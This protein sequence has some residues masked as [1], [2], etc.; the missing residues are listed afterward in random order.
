MYRGV[1]QQEVGGLGRKG[2]AGEKRLLGREFL[3]LRKDL[4]FHARLTLTLCFDG[5]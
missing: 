2:L 4:V 5:K 1:C 3:G